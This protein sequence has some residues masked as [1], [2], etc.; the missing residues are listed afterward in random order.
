MHYG[1]TFVAYIG[2]AVSAHFP[3]EIAD[4]V[5]DHAMWYDDPN[6]DTGRLDLD[7]GDAR[8]APVIERIRNGLP[9]VLP[10]EKQEQLLGLLND[11]NWNVSFFVDRHAQRV[12]PMLRQATV[13]EWLFPVEIIDLFITVGG[14]NA[15]DAYS[16]AGRIRL[17]PHLPNTEQRLADLR[18]DIASE[19]RDS[20]EADRFIQ[21]LREQG[22]NACCVVD[23]Y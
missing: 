12:M 20:D 21:I 23:C 3:V 13:P 14:W 9:G 7:A 18:N 11:H 5:R 16:F 2:T 17:Q 6:C 15:Y 22:L 8:F 4:L 19:I 10:P 1:I